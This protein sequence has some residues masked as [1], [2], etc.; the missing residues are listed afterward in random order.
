MRVGEVL[1][2]L[3]SGFAHGV[4]EGRTGLDLASV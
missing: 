1:V 3:G 2:A 4:A